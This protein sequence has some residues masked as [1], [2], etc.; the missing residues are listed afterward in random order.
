M[1]NA[2]LACMFCVIYLCL[3]PLTEHKLQEGSFVS[4]RLEHDLTHNRHL[5]NVCLENKQMRSLW[6]NVGLNTS[7]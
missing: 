3:S 4:Q 1:C 2:M 5:I 6:E 7:F